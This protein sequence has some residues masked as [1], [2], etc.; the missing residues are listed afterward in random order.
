MLDKKTQKER[1]KS[2]DCLPGSIKESLT[3]EEVQEFLQEEQWSDALFE[4]LDEF[5]VK[6]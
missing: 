4:K 3:E 5:I 1:Q 6:E 2:F